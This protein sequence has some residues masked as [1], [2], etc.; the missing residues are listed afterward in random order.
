[1]FTKERFTRMYEHREAD[2]VP[3]IDSP[4]AGTIRRWQ[5]EGM[6]VGMDWVDYFD[7]D[8]IAGIGVDITP[9]YEEK[10][11]EDTDR[12]QIVT[13]NWGVTMKHFKEEDSSPEFLD[14][15]VV[16][17]A[18]WAEA[19]ARM[20]LD[21]D[22]I[23]WDM[24]K[25][26]YDR[27]VA[28]GRWIIGNFWFGFDVTHSWMMGTENLLMAMID[29]PELVQDMFATY[30]DR[31]MKLFERIWDAGYHFDEV[32]W[33]DDMGYKGTTFFSPATYRQ[34]VQPFHKAAVD[35]AHNKGI[36]AR[37]HSCGNIMSLVPDIVATG[38]D[39]L[40]PLEVKAGMDAIKLKKEYGDKLVLHGGINAVLWDDADAIIAEI[41][42]VVPILK[43]NGGFIF[44]SD[45][46]IPNSVSLD[47]FRKIVAEVKRVGSYD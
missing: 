6:P 5:R 37:L 8:K 36:Y 11:L 3:I 19:K 41:D 43:E 16:D 13:S 39:A 42:R 12:Y 26:N 21:D 7:T 18:S 17:E 27:W 47:N 28:E 30:L 1:M 23:P 33:P 9:R 38:M 45:H 34:M 32:H 25:K 31:C 15:K 29:E 20:T 46:S 4:W 40:N 2:R 35:W 44:S 24:L 10:V 22:R 14:F